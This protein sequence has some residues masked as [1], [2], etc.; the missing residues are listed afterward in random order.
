MPKGP[1][2]DIW[3][4][5]FSSEPLLRP[6]TGQRLWR[7]APQLEGMQAAVSMASADASRVGQQ[8][9]VVYGAVCC[10]IWDGI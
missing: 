8:R 4:M 1:F 7:L 2:S 10:D 5:A 3:Q 9:A 6:Y